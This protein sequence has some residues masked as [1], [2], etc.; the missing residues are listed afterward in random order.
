MTSED[1]ASLLEQK[2]RASNGHLIICVNESFPINSITQL[3]TFIT[4]AVRHS[5]K[6]CSTLFLCEQLLASYSHLSENTR[7][8][9]V[10]PLDQRKKTAPSPS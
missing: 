4:L 9:A 5:Y 7:K 6:P 3:E 8:H 10:F 1:I 2:I